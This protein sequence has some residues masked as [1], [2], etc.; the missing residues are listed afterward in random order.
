LLGFTV[1]GKDGVFYP[2]IA[3]IEGD[4]VLVSAP[5]VASPRFVRFAWENTPRA[6]LYNSAHLPAVPFRTDSQP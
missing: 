6:N 4:S 3:K 2:A 1:A 5:S